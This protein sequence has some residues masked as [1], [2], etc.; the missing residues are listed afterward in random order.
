LDVHSASSIYYAL[1]EP[2]DLLMVLDLV[3]IDSD[4]SKSPYFAGFVVADWE[5]HAIDWTEEDKLAFRA[6]LFSPL[7]RQ[8][9][10]DLLETIKRELE[11]LDFPV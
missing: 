5:D 9:R 7:C 3:Y 1:Q 8:S 4:N 10:I 11:A 2:D 6:W